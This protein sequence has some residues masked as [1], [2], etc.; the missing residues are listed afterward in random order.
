MPC[1]N[2]GVCKDIGNGFQC[3]CPRGFYGKQCQTEALSCRNNPCMF[4]GSCVEQGDSYV[5]VCPP[6]FTGYNCDT[7]INE[8]ASDP[9]ENG[10]FIMP[11]SIH[12]IVDFNLGFFSS[13]DP[14]LFVMFVCSVFFFWK[15]SIY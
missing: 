8:C 4:G 3:Q 9:C 7:E 1:M 2:E 6:G 14:C 10:E 11:S 13:Q 15:V 5:C 12:Y